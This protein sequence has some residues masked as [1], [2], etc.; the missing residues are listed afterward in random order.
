M[1][2][3]TTSARIVPG[4][5][6]LALLGGCAASGTEAAPAPSP[7][8]TS[9]PSPA[10]EVPDIP[11]AGTD[12]AAVTQQIAPVQVRV[13]AVDIDVQVIPVGVRTD[14]LMELPERVDTAGW[15]RYGPDPSSPVGTTVI[16]A[17]VDSLK[18]GVGPFSKLKTLSAGAEILVAD[19]NGV[20]HRYQLTSVENVL[21]AEIPLDRVF[22][23]GGPEQLVLIT[24]GGQFD[25]TSRTYSDNVLVT[26]TPVGS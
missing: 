4:I 3:A 22:D 11:I 17:H 20:E 25:T 1:T 26:A 7:T 24:C 10:P 18:Y 21:K 23:R 8:P 5:L 12:P 2:I 14:G 15:Y 6:V 16:S 9:E 19:A 13:P